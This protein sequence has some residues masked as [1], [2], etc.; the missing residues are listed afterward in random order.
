MWVGNVKNGMNRTGLI[1]IKTK[2]LKGVHS[3]SVHIHQEYLWGKDNSLAFWEITM[4]GCL[5]TAPVQ[6]HVEYGEQTRDVRA[7]PVG[8]GL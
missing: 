6:K 7:P 2:G 5:F 8:A 3:E 4:A 1:I